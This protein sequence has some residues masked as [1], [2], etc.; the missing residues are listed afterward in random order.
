MEFLTIFAFFFSFCNPLIAKNMNIARWS[1]TRAALIALGVY[2]VVY[3]FKAIALYT[4]AKRADQKQPVWC[5]FVPFASTYLMGKLAGEFKLFGK[6]WKNIGLFVM[7]AELA[8][9]VVFFCGYLPEMYMLDRGYYLIEN[10][11]LYFIVA[12]TGIDSA[13]LWIY[14]I[15]RVG[16]ILA[17]IFRLIYLFV[18]AVLYIALFRKYYARGFVPFTIIATIFPVL[19]PFFLFAIRNNGAFDYERY[20]AEQMERLRR[21]QQN[22]YTKPYDNSYGNTYNRP[23]NNSYNSGERQAPPDDP[24]SEYSSGR[25]RTDVGD[26]GDDFFN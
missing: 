21:A 3:V 1:G 25:G 22:S 26:D 20:M 19:T 18:S 8:Y 6:N 12:E 7:L 5:A 24:F 4:M 10:N 2:F 16:N 14:Q 23:Y 13:P 17:W 9:A 15:Y 11:E